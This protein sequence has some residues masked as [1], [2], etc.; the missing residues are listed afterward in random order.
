M[1]LTDV[2]RRERMG[3]VICTAQDYL[4]GMYVCWMEVAGIPDVR[5]DISTYADE[6]SCWQ[7]ATNQY[8]GMEVA[9]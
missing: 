5:I 8:W 2:V 3:V 6:E 9:S 7:D 1:K 4:S